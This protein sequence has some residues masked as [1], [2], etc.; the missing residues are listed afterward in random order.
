MIAFVKV[1]VDDLDRQ[2]AFYETVLGMKPGPRMPADAYDQVFLTG[3]SGGPPLA[4]LS[5]RD[6]TELRTGEAVLG[7]R[8]LDVDAVV[9]AAMAAGG[10]V[11]V[12]PKTVPGSGMR[13]A[14]VLD[15]EGHAME[16]LEGA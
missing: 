7:F 4:L 2:C 3:P 11:R 1:V 13:V 16:L 9:R 6:G 8:V 10:S 15:P 14:V 5:Y 12:E